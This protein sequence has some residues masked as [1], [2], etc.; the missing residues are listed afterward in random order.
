MPNELRAYEVTL[1][2]EEVAIKVNCITKMTLKDELKTAF[3]IALQSLKNNTRKRKRSFFSKSRDNEVANENASEYDDINASNELTN[4]DMQVQWFA[5]NVAQITISFIKEKSFNRKWCEK[6][7]SEFGR[8][9]M[10]S[11][12]H[13]I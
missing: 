3:G 5:P 6:A 2:Y 8:T 13:L 12:F 1:R 4:V 7:M 10:M 11:V 9:Q